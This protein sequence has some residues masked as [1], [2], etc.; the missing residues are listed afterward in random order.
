MRNH[1]V[2]ARP[3]SARR[4]GPAAMVAAVL[5]VFSLASM[6]PSAGQDPDT[7]APVPQVQ[8]SASVARNRPPAD[9]PKDASADDDPVTVEELRQG[10]SRTLIETLREGG[11][12]GLLIVALSLVSVAF[13]IEHALTIRR[14]VLMP[15]RVMHELEVLIV[16][17]HVD[18]AL[19]RSMAP[20]NASL[21]ADVVRA[22]LER[23]RSSEFGFAEYRAAVEEAG[24]QQVGRLYRKTD[25]LGVIGAIAPM[26]GLTGTVLGMIRAFNE[27]AAS[28]GAA[29]PDQLAAGI[30]QALVTTLLGLLVAIPTMVAFSF[31]RNRIDSLVAEAG[32][33]IERIMLPLGRRTG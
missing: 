22:G 30:G 26:L 23:F 2:L 21:A 31:F 24:E 18:R 8:P 11:V 5:G 19:Q 14:S 17:G 32:V 15:H 28:G 1:R 10:R 7:A 29:R 13:M 16:Q 27:I 6:A 33:R 4:L 25:V 20:E 12:V 9:D 3:A